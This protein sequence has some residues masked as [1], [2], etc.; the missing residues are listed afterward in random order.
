LPNELDGEALVWGV[1]AY[2]AQLKDLAAQPQTA[3]QTNV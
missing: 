2:S 1:K 3:E